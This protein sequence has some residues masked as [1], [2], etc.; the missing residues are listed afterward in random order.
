M[1]DAFGQRLALPD[2]ESAERPGLG[3]VWVLSADGS[4]T[5]L[6]IIAAVHD[7]HVLAWPVTAPHPDAAA[8]A[9]PFAL[10]NG[11]PLVGWP[12]AAFGVTMAAL[13]RRIQACALSQQ[14]MRDIRWSLPE[15]EAREGHVMFPI[16]DTAE[17][18]AAFETVCVAAWQMGE[19]EW[20]AVQEGAATFSSSALR[21]GNVDGRVLTQQLSIPVNR[22]SKLTRGLAIPTGEETAKVI[23]LFPEGTRPTDLL[24]APHGLEA[25]VLSFPGSKEAVKK[26]AANRGESEAATRS[27]AWAMASSNAARVTGQGDPFAQAAERV[28]AALVSLIDGDA[29]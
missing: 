11:S 7:M 23:E 8:P 29:Q 14:R 24:E 1:N 5:G 25:Q 27:R 10:S 26:A 6:V 22:A 21:E 13:D 18:N 17:T 15:N 28:S 16:A 20:P 19:W 2:G 3:D 9:F 4:D 12:D